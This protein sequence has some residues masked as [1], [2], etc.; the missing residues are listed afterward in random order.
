MDDGH[1]RFTYEKRIAELFDNRNLERD[2]R[3]LLLY[4]M[5][6]H[7]KRAMVV[8]EPLDYV[9][10]SILRTMDGRRPFH[11]DGALTILDHL[12]GGI[13]SILSHDLEKAARHVQLVDRGDAED[14]A[15]LGGYDNARIVAE[16]RTEDQII[17]DLDAGKQDATLPPE[18]RRYMQL[19]RSGLC[20]TANDFAQRMKISVARVRNIERRLRRKRKRNENRI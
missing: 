3:E 17:H 2:T 10:E 15:P 16:S 7:G 9:N 12:R 13:D 5:R 11:F 6:R 4:V 20:K 18:E 14:G 1:H 19:Q 8:R